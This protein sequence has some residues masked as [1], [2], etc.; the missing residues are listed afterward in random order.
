MKSN[1]QLNFKEYIAGHNVV[2]QNQSNPANPLIKGALNFGFKNVIGAGAKSLRSSLGS[3]FN[4][5]SSGSNPAVNQLISAFN[6][7]NNYLQFT[8]AIPMSDGLDQ[9]QAQ[10][11]AIEE[12][13]QHAIKEDFVR[14]YRLNLDR[15]EVVRVDVDS[16][17]KLFKFRLRYPIYMRTSDRINTSTH[18][19]PSQTF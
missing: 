15:P 17:N 14:V 8:V 12:G 10:A 9:K 13:K 3:G 5:T 11:Q 18:Y 6:V 16:K 2:A 4:D 19:R 1:I 7:D